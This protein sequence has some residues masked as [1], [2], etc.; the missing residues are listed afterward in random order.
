MIVV[1][2]YF[3]GNLR[4]VEKGL[5]KLGF[6]VE[7]TSDAKKIAKADGLVLPGVGH[8]DAAI[9]N[10]RKQKLDKV[11]I[12][13]IASGR[14][15]LGICLG[16]QLL[17][18]ESEEGNVKGLGIFKGKV[19]KFELPDLKVPHMGWNNIKIRNPKSEILKGVKDGAC[20]YFVHSYYTEPE[21]KSIIATTTTYGIDFASSISK[22]NV[23]AIQCHPEKSGEVG[24]KILK[25]FGDNCRK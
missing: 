18:T 8:F 14:P 24:L 22:D 10:L 17:F 13:Y 11:V 4:S 19:R 3:L 16:Y 21:D 12:D 15:F 1:V 25:N 7:V 6:E 2:D 9:T 23:F 5:E 20:L